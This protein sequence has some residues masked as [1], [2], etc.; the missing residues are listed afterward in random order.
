MCIAIVKPI[1]TTISDEHLRNSAASNRD[2]GGYAFVEA[3]GK[4]LVRK[5]Y[6]NVDKF[7]ED[8]RADEERLG[9]TSPALIHFRISTGGGVSVDNCHPFLFKHGALIHNGWFFSGYGDKSDTRLLMEDI[10]EHLTKA[11]VESNK[12]ELGEH[13]GMNNKVAILF[14]DRTVSIINEERGTW[15][16][17]V[18]YSN[19][20]FRR[21]VMSTYYGAGARRPASPGVQVSNHA[22]SCASLG[23]SCGVGGY[24]V[25]GDGDFPGMN[26]VYG[27]VVSMDRLGR[28]DY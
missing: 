7:I 8:Y 28:G 6:F 13:F 5:G 2:G 24:E 15:E 12:K 11:R 10:G 27:N 22:A 18:W 3:D 26:G 14:R 21:S 25:D 23:A 4:M 16:E 19:T 20:T 9:A 17:G 1:G